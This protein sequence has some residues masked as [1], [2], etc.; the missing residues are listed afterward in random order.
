[1]GALTSKHKQFTFRV[2]EPR[3]FIEMDETEVSYYNLR[4]E[5]LKAKRSRILPINYWMADKKRFSNEASIFS[6]PSIYFEK[7]SYFFLDVTLQESQNINY[8]ISNIKGYKKIL[9]KFVDGSFNN[10]KTFCAKQITKAVFHRLEIYDDLLTS[11]KK[12]NRSIISSFDEKIK[13]T[14][15]IFMTNPRT[16]SPMLNAY[17]FKHRDN[18]LF[19]SFSSFASNILKTEIPLSPYT[20]EASFN[21]HYNLQDS[22]IITSCFNTLPLP[23]NSN[24]ITLTPLYLNKT[25]RIYSKEIQSSV[26]LYLFMKSNKIYQPSFLSLNSNHANTSLSIGQHGFDQFILKKI[27]QKYLERLS[28]LYYIL[29]PKKNNTLVLLETTTITNKNA[30]SLL[31]QTITS[32]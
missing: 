17:L 25:M 15:I 26:N 2:W 3:T 12:L 22:T 11:H 7:L 9:D 6:N 4:S 32:I 19:T 10:I 8:I 27:S 16:E 28:L 5:H 24:M 29:R 23:Q 31:L 18:F 1:M 20:I 13:T 30:L 21:G 14:N